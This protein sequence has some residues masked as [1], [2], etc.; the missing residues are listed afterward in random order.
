[1]NVSNDCLVVNWNSN[2]IRLGNW[3]RFDDMHGVWTV[4]GDLDFNGVW[5]VDWYVDSN[6][7]WAIYGHSNLN[8]GEK[9]KLIICANKIYIVGGEGWSVLYLLDDRLAHGPNVQLGQ[10]P[11][12]KVIG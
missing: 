3:H 6:R 2:W 12:T 7:Y 11:K 9:M 1:M 10:R 4:N 8:K 5:S